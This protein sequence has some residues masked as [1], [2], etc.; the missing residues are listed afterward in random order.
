MGQL[1]R[2]TT[3]RRRNQGRHR[4]TARP[5]LKRRPRLEE[6][7]TRL[8]PSNSTFYPA[9]SMTP[10]EQYMLEKINWARAHP[11]DQ[12]A[13]FGI[14]LNEGIPSDQAHIAPTPK[15]P[16]APNQLL[17]NSIKSYL[18]NVQNDFMATGTF[19]DKDHYLNGTTP[20][21]RAQA[22]NYGPWW[23]GI[24]EN[25]DVRPL[26]SQNPGAQELMTTLDQ[27]FQKLFVD[28]GADGDYARGHRRNML[29][30][31]LKEVGS[32]IV[33][34]PEP[35]GPALYVGQDFG[36][37]SKADCFITGVAYNDV[38]WVGFYGIGTG[39]AGM[40]VFAHNTQTG[41]NYSTI[42]GPS[43][44]YALKVTPGEYVL[45]FNLFGAPTTGGY[46][47]V[48]GGTPPWQVQDSVKWDIHLQLPNLLTTQTTLYSKPLPG[49]HRAAAP[50]VRDVP[51][52]PKVTFWVNP[53]RP[54]RLS[55]L[56]LTPDLG[57]GTAPVAQPV[58]SWA[59][60]TSRAP[61]RADGHLPTAPPASLD[62]VFAGL[63][64]DAFAGL[65]S[66]RLFQLGRLNR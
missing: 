32:G 30:P 65:A 37:I 5:A 49:G 58:V 20:E 48:I 47:Y 11:M 29:D 36:A 56:A 51:I 34:G 28:Q 3:L 16:L 24:A 7:E 4:G 13:K 57:V 35:G 27:S 55:P 8:V 33:S 31:L 23:Y 44:G 21:S 43:G 2:R 45:G 1:W 38:N 52:P 60:T 61:T 18:P 50:A 10:A 6:L 64:D 12:A 59:F 26:P 53:L 39:L 19:N 66:G 41:D 40:S 54:P 17:L 62:A 42:T 9:I 25:L 22:A 15:P 14:D 63:V 46:A